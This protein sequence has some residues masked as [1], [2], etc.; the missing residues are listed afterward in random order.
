MCVGDCS[1]DARAGVWKRD[2]N[3]PANVR[4]ASDLPVQDQR[5]QRLLS[6][7]PHSAAAQ[8]A[9]AGV[10]PDDVVS[11]QRHRHTRGHPQATFNFVY[12]V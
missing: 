7:T 12:S 3:H 4:S 10:L 9:H 2:G 6:H 11:Q 1:A 5:P 8:A